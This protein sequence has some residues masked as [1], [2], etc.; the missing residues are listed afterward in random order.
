MRVTVNGEGLEIAEGTTVRELI[1]ALA[2]DGG[3][4]A[5]EVDREIVPRAR[6]GETVLAEG[7]SIEIVQ[8]VGGG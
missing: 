7:A 6:H 2:L 1:A 8:F 3:P 5:V 4:V